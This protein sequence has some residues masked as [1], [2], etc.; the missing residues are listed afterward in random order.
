MA[1][2]QVAIRISVAWWLRWYILG[3]TLMC[4]MTGCQPNIE[5]VSHWVRRSIRMRIE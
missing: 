1:Q 4:R 3:V 5:R 2:T